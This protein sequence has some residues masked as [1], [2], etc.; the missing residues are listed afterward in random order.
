M[1]NGP[2]PALKPIGGYHL[3]DGDGMVHAVRIKADHNVTYSAK[4][5]ET[6]KLQ[7]VRSSKTLHF[8][9]G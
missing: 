8:S 7:E 4:Y 1:R 3:F 5:V 9:I 2:N 6:L